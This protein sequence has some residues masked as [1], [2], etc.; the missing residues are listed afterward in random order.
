MFAILL[1][2]SVS[3]YSQDKEKKYEVDKFY[4]SIGGE[5][6]FSFVN[7]NPD[8]EQTDLRFSAWLHLQGFWHYDFAKN[9]GGFIGLGSR[10][11][12]YTTTPVSNN[13]YLEGFTVYNSTTK[14]YELNNTFAE[15][16]EITTVKRR[17]YTLTIPIGLKIGNMAR[18]RFVFFGGEIEFPFHYK[19]KAWVNDKKVEKSDWWFSRQTNPYLL[20]SFIGVQFPMG[21]NIKFKWYLTEF[22]N[23]D[24]SPSNTSL[25]PYENVD[26]QMFYFSL[27]MN[28]FNAKRAIK[29]I[30]TI[31]VQKQRDSYQM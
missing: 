29:Q 19:N 16:D 20:S 30:Q 25:K 31:G 14:E 22:L 17:A 15:G 9:F 8:V 6:I 26:S 21:I 12:G 10:N 11:I 2:I 5:F 13:I 3:V 18:D 23:K 1:L 28:L 7:T 4:T 27:G 24:Y